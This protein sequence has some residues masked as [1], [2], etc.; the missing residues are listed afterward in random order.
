MFRVA[1]RHALGSRRDSFFTLQNHTQQDGPDEGRR[2]A[3]DRSPLRDRIRRGVPRPPRDAAGS[4][5][6]APRR[7]QP[8]TPGSAAARGS[9]LRGASGI[10]FFDASREGAGAF[11]RV[12]RRHAR[13][14]ERGPEAGRRLSSRS[15]PRRGRPTLSAVPATLE[16]SAARSR[17]AA[18]AVRAARGEAAARNEPSAGRPAAAGHD[19][20][21]GDD[22][23]PR[24]HEAGPRL[25][26]RQPHAHGP[27]RARRRQ[28]LALQA[29]APE[30]IP[31]SILNPARVWRNW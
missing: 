21:S 5:L 4:A 26:R 25:R 1:V 28:A 19:A 2:S 20:A 24:G 29:V 13:R 22:A 16:S 3:G 9:R 10:R 7:L 8:G 17:A 6:G 18:P 27:A 15:A 31:G 12:A 23:S 14:P 30:S 11:A